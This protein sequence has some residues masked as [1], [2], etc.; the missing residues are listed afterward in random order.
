MNELLKDTIEAQAN[1]IKH[2]KQIMVILIISWLLSIC[3]GFGAFVWYESQFE[4]ETGTIT[5]VT[6]DGDNANA[7]YNEVQGDQYNDNSTH[8]EGDK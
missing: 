2:L 5:E 7:E 1:T 6:T 3:F 4:Y 8:K